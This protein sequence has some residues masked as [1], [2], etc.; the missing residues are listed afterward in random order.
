MTIHRWL[1]GEDLKF[2]RPVYFGRNRF[3][4]LHDLKEWERDQPRKAKPEAA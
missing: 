1:A 3:W 4:R 2:P